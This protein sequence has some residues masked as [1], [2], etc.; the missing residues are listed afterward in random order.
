MAADDVKARAELLDA[1]RWANEFAWAEIESLAVHLR[2]E[3]RRKGEVVCRE[4]AA[5][6]SLFVIA[7]GSVSILKQDTGEQPKLLARLGP[8]QTIGEMA[9]LDGQP[10]SATVAAAE[11]LVLLVLDRAALERLVDEKPRLGVKLLW[12]LA[13]FLSQRLRQTS[14][15]LADKL[16]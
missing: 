14:G 11:D 6:P 10:R 1:T 3:R 7:T 9:L 13:R 12:K 4:G 16:K 8:G 5:E 2:V 15:N